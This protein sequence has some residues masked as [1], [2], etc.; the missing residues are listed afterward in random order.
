M[1][2]VQRA[3]GILTQPR[4][5]WGRIAEEPATTSSLYT[6]YAVILA[7]VPLALQ[8]VVA[9]IWAGAGG[10]L[11]GIVG[12]VLSIGL[13]LAVIYVMGLI[14]NALAPNFGGVRND[15][16]AQKLMVYASTPLW[17]MGILTALLGLIP[18]LGAVVGILLQL[19]AFAYAAYLIYLGAPIVMRVTQQQAIVYALILAA[20]WFVIYL[21][22]AALV[23]LVVASLFA[24]AV[25][26]SGNPY[27]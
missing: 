7:A 3:T 11:A 8:I 2:I 9:L 4:P 6:G 18:L 17:V 23:G 21:V 13:A 24:A 26:T 14:A 25:M 10:A 19:L 12:G 15:I 5:E 20:I 22:V 16:G 27:R 1:N